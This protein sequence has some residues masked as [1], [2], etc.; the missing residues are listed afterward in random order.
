MAFNF[1]AE[2]IKGFKKGK[3]DLL[4]I[5]LSEKEVLA[6]QSWDFQHQMRLEMFILQRSIEILKGRDPHSLEWRFEAAW[7]FAPD[8]N[9]NEGDAIL[10]SFDRVVEHNLIYIQDYSAHNEWDGYL[11]TLAGAEDL[12]NK[13][14]DEMSEQARN[15]IVSGDFKKNNP[16]PYTD[17]EN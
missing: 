8:L 3:K 13:I 4:A 16:Y 7:V 11:D 5:P 15:Q 6:L 9:V 17:F 14:L 10:H 2:N 1:D 12:R